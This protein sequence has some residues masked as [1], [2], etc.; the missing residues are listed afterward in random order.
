MVRRLFATVIFCALNLQGVVSA[1][2]AAPS[3]SFDTDLTNRVVSRLSESDRDVARR[4]HVSAEN[5][6]VT[7]EATGLTNAQA[8]KILVDVRAVPG[9]TK[10]K[11]RLQVRM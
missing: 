3:E 7:L 6:V 11:N 2:T 4:V 9:V 1:D 8:V 10:V 5:G